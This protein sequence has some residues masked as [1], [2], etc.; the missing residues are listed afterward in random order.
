MGIDKDTKFFTREEV[1]KHNTETDQWLIYGDK[2][3]DISKFIKKH[4]GGKVIS[5]YQ[6]QDATEPIAAFHPDTKKLNLYLK[7]LEVG[8]LEK[9]SFEKMPNVVREFRKLRDEFMSEGKFDASV[10]FYFLGILHVI[11]LELIAIFIVSKWG[12]TSWSLL[13][14]SL[15]L[16]TAQSQAGWTQ[17]DYGHLSVFNKNRRMNQF[18]HFFT[19][20]FLKGASSGWWKTRH[21]RHHAKTNVINLDPDLHTEPLFVFSD[22][23]SLLKK[24]WKLLPYQHLY[25][26]FLGPPLVTTVI[27][28]P[29]NLR[30]VI[31]YKLWDDLCWV[32]SYYI[33]FVLIYSQFL[34]GWQCVILYFGMR[35]WESH[36]FTWVTSMSHLPRPMRIQHVD[37]NWI[38]LNANSSQ[39]ITNGLFHDW[40][41]GHLNYQIEHHLFP[42]MPRHNFKYIAPKIKALCLKNNIPYHQKSMYQCC[43]DV[44]EKLQEVAKKYDKQYVQYKS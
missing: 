41:T 13:F 12:G 19:I 31:V 42:S 10:A 21:N 7:G 28:V 40:F 29:Q 15:F 9:E 37:Q 23:E 17:H 38:S 11:I 16:A 26:W 33:R 30:Y 18:F 3:Y 20:G 5:Y 27:F 14:A 43:V 2:V 25:W 35:F 22:V 44:V 4:P 1:A 8:S 39:N 6:G 24:G 36:W 34:T 32:L